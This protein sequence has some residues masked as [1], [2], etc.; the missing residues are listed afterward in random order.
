VSEARDEYLK[1]MF[2][3]SKRGGPEWFEFVEAFRVFTAYELERSLST[4]TGEALKALGMNQRMIELRN[5]F[6]DIEKIASKL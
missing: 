4:P 1:A 3:L 6:I 5:D 2:R